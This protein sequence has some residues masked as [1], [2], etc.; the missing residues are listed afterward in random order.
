MNLLL[1][2][3]EGLGPVMEAAEAEKKCVDDK[4]KEES[5]FDWVDTVR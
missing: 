2:L 4:C 3:F 1:N 5:I